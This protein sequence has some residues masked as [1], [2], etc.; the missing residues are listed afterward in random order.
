M[1]HRHKWVYLVEKIDSDNHL[2]PVAI[3][4]GFELAHTLLK[5]DKYLISKMQINIEYEH[6]I[7][8]CEHWH[9]E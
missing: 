8:K 4:T 6:G 3:C 1:N 2:E 7:G 9:Y 5:A